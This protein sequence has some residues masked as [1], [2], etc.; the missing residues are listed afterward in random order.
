M[1]DQR[2]ECDQ[3]LR[4]M[5][6]NLS[7]CRILCLGDLM[8]DRFVYGQVDRIS[9][10]APVPI[11]RIGEMHVMLGGVGN[12]ARN[13]VSLGGTAVVVGVCCHDDNGRELTSI[14]DSIPN[15]VNAAVLSMDRPTT[16]KVRVIAGHQQLLRLDHEVAAPIDADAEAGVIENL[17]H[18]AAACHAVVLSDYAKGVLTEAVTRHAI[19]LAQRLGLPVFVDPKRRDMRFYRGATVIK[20]NR[21]ELA[22]ATAMQVADQTGLVTAARVLLAETEAQAILVT[23][24]E[25]GMTLVTA[26][27]EANSIP[28]TAREV[29]DVSGAGDTVIATAALVYSGG[30]S[31]QAAMQMANVA[32]G[33]AVSKLGTAAITMAE[34]A[35]AMV[36]DQ[37]S[38]TETEG[39][40]QT[41][42]Q[43]MAT[44]EKWKRS[45]LIVGFT[46]GCFDIL[47][48][49]HVQMLR[50]ARQECDRLVVA[51][52]TD[53]SVRRLKGFNR[54]LNSLDDRSSVIEGLQ[55]SN[56]VVSFDQDTPVA[57]IQQLKPD[58]LIKGADYTI[59]SVVGADAVK[60]WGGRVV[61][62]PV[63]VGRSTS[64]IVDRVR[65]MVVPAVG[66]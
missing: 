42:V 28:S 3:D 24:A 25:E 41:T 31:L 57:L 12:V 66:P 49:G 40:L 32:A 30:H 23:R 8:L 7:A 46:N 47:H 53:A 35:A 33:V 52:N 6:N 65:Q 63:A 22:E 51:V 16:S 37:R 36:D 11:V 38:S 17:D 29:F 39:K 62:V 61:L 54:P 48:A 59:S 1:P 19:T 58:V 20:P 5:L 43:A 27:G 13:I 60:A 2:R 21:K 55:S 9:P 56:L 10:E 14:L 15:L 50:A 45:G 64:L 26:D 4:A 44:V 34:L 18:W